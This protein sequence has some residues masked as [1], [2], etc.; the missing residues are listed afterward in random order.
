MRRAPR[1]SVLAL[2]GLAGAAAVALPILAFA[3]P[4]DFAPDLRADPV[5]L[6]SGPAVYS[7]TEGGLG[8]GR[9]LLRFDGYVTNVGAGPLEISGNPQ[10]AGGVR[11]LART[12][13]GADPS[14]PVA[15][16]EVRYEEEDSHEHFH[17]KRA[18]RYSLWNEARTAQVA[19]AQKVGFCLYDLEDAPGFSGTGSPLFPVYDDDVTHYCE[20]GDPASTSLRM[21]VSAGWR[22]VYSQAL[23]YQWIDV[24][25][26]PPGTYVVGAEA[27][28]DNVLWEGGGAAEVN[29]PA[30][31][32]QTV[33]VPG[34][35]AQPVAIAQ[36]GAT[37]AVP[38]SAQKFGA[39]ADANLRY[40][41]VT[42]PARGTLSLAPG[43]DFAAN[44]PLLYTPTPG[45]RGADAF[46]YVARSLAS[47]FPT[48]PQAATVTIADTQ[49]SVAISGAPARMVAGTSA[50][51]TATIRNL[52]GGV[53]WSAT[54]GSVSAAGLYRAPG[55]PPAGDVAAVRAA[56]TASP[57]VAAEVRIRITAA[58]T[59]TAKPDP[60]PRLSAGRRLLSAL[61]ARFIGPRTL[62]AKVATGRKGG[63]VSI[64]A[65]ARGKVLGSC[66]SRVGA[67]RG[68]VCRF[69]I[70]GGSPPARVRLTA[71]LRP[72]GGGLVVRRALARR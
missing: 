12:A 5:G 32:N 19:P 14:V 1:R 11:Q 43:Q 21:G 55:S 48:N 37:Q 25:D 58:P 28:P 45:Y 31:R 68:F 72:R 54:A 20:Q 56:S 34:W 47:S 71:K 36:T 3:A 4:E 2:L 10:D 59:A 16:P 49:P 66:A 15:T 23:A 26:T 53:T 70:R 17:L 35:V 9:L 22:D 6:V 7:N 38:L 63:R 8:N 24:S 50:Q 52:P 46:T 62:I 60:W 64:T 29:A 61:K 40:R 57:A 51:L 44:V 41:V 69:T 30:F 42:P 33:T 27:D 18:M 13:P 65:S 39:Q 67:R